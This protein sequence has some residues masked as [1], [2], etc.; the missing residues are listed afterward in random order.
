MQ[1]KLCDFKDCF[2]NKLL[3]MYASANFEALV[4]VAILGTRRG[5]DRVPA[6]SS[7]QTPRWSLK[8][9]VSP[10]TYRRCP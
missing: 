5:A 2:S 6:Q 8:P 3:N 7:K 10:G 4:F 1:K 9:E